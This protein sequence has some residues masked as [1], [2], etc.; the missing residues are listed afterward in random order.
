MKRMSP[1]LPSLAKRSARCVLLRARTFVKPPHLPMSRGPCTAPDM[2]RMLRFANVYRLPNCTDATIAE[3]AGV[4]MPTSCSLRTIQSSRVQVAERAGVD[5]PT[6]CFLDTFKQLPLVCRWQ[7]VQASASQRAASRAPVAPARWKSA[8]RAW[9]QARRARA[10]CAAA[11]PAC[12]VD[13]G[14][15]A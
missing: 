10:S 4:D 7:S 2:I 8:R 1:W 14:T 9:L 6:S 12:H 13:T 15:Y 5:I 3:S 11:S